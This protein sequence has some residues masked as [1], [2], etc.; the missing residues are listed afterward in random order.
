MGLIPLV[1]LLGS[2]CYKVRYLAHEKNFVE[3]TMMQRGVGGL[4][5]QGQ[6][7][8]ADLARSGGG[9]VCPHGLERGTADR[10]PVPVPAPVTP[11]DHVATEVSVAPLVATAIGLPSPSPVPP[12]GQQLLAAARESLL[13]CHEELRA[14]NRNPDKEMVQLAD[15]RQILQ[16]LEGLLVPGQSQEIVLEVLSFLR[17]IA[18]EGDLLAANQ[19]AVDVLRRHLPLFEELALS[20]TDNVAIDGFLSLSCVNLG[21][22]RPDPSVMTIMGRLLP[23]L[24]ELVLSD[25]ENMATNAWEFIKSVAES[26]DPMPPAAELL[27][28]RLADDAAGNTPED[29]VALAKEF[30]ADL[31]VAEMRR[32][33][34]GLNVNQIL[35]RLRVDPLAAIPVPVGIDDQRWAQ[36]A[37]NFGWLIDSVV[38]PERQERRVVA[39]ADGPVEQ[40]VN[41]RNHLK[42]ML[43][44]GS[45]HGA[46]PASWFCKIMRTEMARTDQQALRREVVK[47]FLLMRQ[48]LAQGQPNDVL[49]ALLILEVHADKCEDQTITGL[50]EARLRLVTAAVSHMVGGRPEDLIP[51]LLPFVVNEYKLNTLKQL[52]YERA[53]AAAQAAGRPLGDEEGGIEVFLYQLL[54]YQESL[55]CSFLAT[56]ASYTEMGAG[57]SGPFN[58]DL[59]LILN[60]I[61]QRDV[62]Y[63]FVK[64][65]QLMDL[66]RKTQAFG[67]QVGDLGNPSS[68][69]RYRAHL[70]STG[71]R[72]EFVARR[73]ADIEAAAREQKAWMLLEGK[74]RLLEEP[75][76]VPVGDGLRRRA[77]PQETRPANRE[78]A[79][80]A[81]VLERLGQPPTE[82]ALAALIA[83][84]E[85]LASGWSAFVGAQVPSPADI[86]A[87]AAEEWDGEVEILWA[88]HVK[89]VENGLLEGFLRTGGYLR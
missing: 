51:A 26:V 58:A 17:E 69:G 25:D 89:I 45:G 30:L 43:L 68:I 44:I 29:V 53:R 21:S 84:P 61:L 46:Y 73:R 64:N 33:N 11:T 77:I 13:I 35:A 52:C 70:E 56:D 82:E 57:G 32:Q 41:L 23:R 8:R 31:V 7:N 87:A 86:A 54:R 48:L 42:Q 3:G 49:E 81:L 80:A 19:G 34:P 60:A 83:A 47:I 40:L 50:S 72:D 12:D 6:G 14:I 27:I 37:G 71:R 10:Q 15:C 75:L 79:K 9:G 38:P 5:E 18:T 76:L 74:M 16:R 78:Q 2:F 28:N 88:E 85:D 67:A 55:N 39:T 36:L 24:G 20:R 4:G 1:D 63:D 22:E 65:S 66:V 59:R 62:F